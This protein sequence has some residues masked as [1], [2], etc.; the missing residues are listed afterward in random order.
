MCKFQFLLGH[1]LSN[2]DWHSIDL[3]EGFQDIINCVNGVID[4][5]APLKPM[6]F[7]KQTWVDS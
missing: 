6:R 1:K 5:Y 2:F 7:N 3:N 4:I